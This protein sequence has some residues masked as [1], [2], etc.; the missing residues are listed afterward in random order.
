MCKLEHELRIRGVGQCLRTYRWIKPSSLNR[1]FECIMD[2]SAAKVRL[3]NPN[4]LCLDLLRR[5]M[6]LPLLMSQFVTMWFDVP[7]DPIKV[8]GGDKFI[9]RHMLILCLH[10]FHGWSFMNSG[11]YAEYGR[12]LNKNMFTFALIIW[13]SLYVAKTSFWQVN[14]LASKNFIKLHGPCIHSLYRRCGRF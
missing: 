13:S 3:P 8:S 6:L 4:G 5:V 7:F 14:L 10:R 11:C 12:S 1:L 9:V 2:H